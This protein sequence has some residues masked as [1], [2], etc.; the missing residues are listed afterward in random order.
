VNI[1]LTSNEKW[2]GPWFS[3]HHY[4]DTLAKLG[5][6]VFFLDPMLSWELIPIVKKLKIKTINEN[7][8]IISGANIMPGSIG[9]FFS[10][11]DRYLHRSIEL[12][13]A[14]RDIDI[15]IEW[16]FD[17]F[18]LFTK[19]SKSAQRI[20][21][22][23][24][25]YK[26]ISTDAAHAHLADLIVVVNK[27]L[28]DNYSLRHKNKIIHI[29]HGFVKGIHLPPNDH[30][31]HNI[32]KDLPFVVYAGT[33]NDDTNY[34][35]ISQVADTLN[36]NIYLLGPK[37]KN[38]TTQLDALLKNNNIKYCGFMKSWELGSILPYAKAGLIPYRFDH[39]SSG[40]MRTPLKTMTYLSH[41]IPVISS[42]PTGLNES[43]CSVVEATNEG[44]FIKACHTAINT[45]NVEVNLA[46]MQTRL[47]YEVQISKI[48]SKLNQ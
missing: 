29:P 13:L 35:L 26:S 47:G 14:E 15:D 41:G 37:S 2:E 3:K 5:H 45:R 6:Q 4:A 23:V 30:I 38:N 28:L 40:G 24:D 36:V 19:R 22:V 44:D 33:F 11:N 32:K 10:L 48:I 18:R 42:I 7:L 1:L 21:H 31:L 16:I 34:S 46:Y 8:H 27:N 25:P 20:Y 43:L 17:P 12:F 9:K 39:L